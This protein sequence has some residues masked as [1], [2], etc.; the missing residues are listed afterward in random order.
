MAIG[1]G[2]VEASAIFS[3]LVNESFGPGGGGQGMGVGVG[4]QDIFIADAVPVAGDSVASLQTGR[5]GSIFP[6]RFR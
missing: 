5:P 4:G 6:D 2:L 1:F 3:G